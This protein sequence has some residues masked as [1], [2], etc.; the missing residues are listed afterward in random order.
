MT[1]PNDFVE[2]DHPSYVGFLPHHSVDPEG[3]VVLLADNA[4]AE[5][6]TLGIAWHLGLVETEARPDADV[7]AL[8][9][10]IDAVLSNLPDGTIAQFILRSSRDLRGA[11]KAWESAEK[12]TDPVLA[13]L[14][15]CRVAA[16]ERL[17]LANAVSHF[18]VRRFQVLFTI[19]RPGTWQGESIGG[20]EALRSAACADDGA[21]RRVSEAYVKNRREIVDLAKTL[22]SLFAQAGISAQRLNGEMMAVELHRA[23]NPLRS[24]TMSMPAPLEGERLAER[25]ALSPLDVDLDSGVVGLDEL[26]HKIVSV[27]HLPGA[28]RAGMLMRSLGATFLD[29]VPELDLVFN[30]HVGDQ[31]EIRSAF[32][33]N[34]R[35][36]TDQ[37]KDAHQSPTMQP[38]L[39]ELVAIERELASGARVVSVRIHA[40]ARAWSKDEAANHARSLQAAF[41]TMGFRSIVED[42][43]AGTIFLQCLPLAYR[44][45]LDR[46]M[47]RG[48]KALT[49]NLAHLVPLYG[50]FAGTPTPTQII[51]NRRG[52]PVTL[53]FFNAKEV[54]H[55]IVTGKS[56][57]GK[58]VFAND[59]ILSA[60]RTGGRVT[61]LDRGGSYRKLAG[62]V[63]GEYVSYDAKRPPRLNPCGA[64]GADGSCPEET[65]S[66][67]RDWL[68]E[69]ATH[70]KGDLSVRDQGLLSMV[71]RKAFAA[72]RS[73]E[74]F[75][76]DIH[77]ALV[78]LAGEHPA[79]KDLAVCL[80][81]YV[82]DGPY[83][84]F[85]DGPN[86]IDFANPFVAVD[87]A[88]AALED[89][90]T[91]VLVMALMHRIAD[92]AR[93]WLSDDKYLIVDEAWTLL[94]SPATARFIENVSRTARKT[95]LSLV[96]LSQQITDLAGATGA[97]ILAQASYKVC[98]HQ[99]AE[100]IRRAADLL[101]L[102]AR[103]VELYGS[104]RTVAG[105]YSEFLVKTP[106]SSG[107]ARLVMDPFSYWISTSDPADRKL[108]ETL[109]TKSEARG[110]T[111]REALR[112]ALIEASV[113]APRG[114]AAR[115][116]K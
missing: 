13:E 50:A 104:L 43:L 46:P 35:M 52:E 3:D 109:V 1:Q 49:M 20:L 5:P 11:V 88:D 51:L 41:Q 36:A 101:G 39:G 72:K 86:E 60:L 83:A 76:S 30:V 45:N 44:P 22:E 9:A 57:A 107:V 69:M 38:Q 116:G 19:V 4:D 53:S 32:G 85:F 74:V 90:V 42:A 29:T 102:N 31:E 10:R 78:A 37:S 81:D 40:V 8:A 64:S 14:G 16:L 7:G 58:S 91:S 65:N 67:L 24:R 87:L 6:G 106:F 75:V 113:L 115:T 61:V 92:A 28:T 33:A 114:A 111:G 17:S 71:V 99:D 112:A 95:R 63:G 2:A 55:A 73:Q 12:T 59:L 108:L 105:V 97:A 80:S 68:T 66:F 25:A 54:P 96:I 82:K 27:T 89:A 26:F 23:L 79:A 77:A 103:E 110:V 93:R 84:R 98:L 62:M 100:A 18:V 21:T 70:G 15:F 94:K 48:R 56:G 47:R 34:R